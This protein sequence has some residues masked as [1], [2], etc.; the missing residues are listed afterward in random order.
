VHC[1]IRIRRVT[2]VDW[3]PGV[4]Y[5]TEYND[6]AARWYSRGISTRVAAGTDFFS[7][8][9]DQRPVHCVPGVLSVGEVAKVWN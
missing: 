7:Q 3:E 1:S 4:R 5:R 6:G 8:G 9:S 2:G